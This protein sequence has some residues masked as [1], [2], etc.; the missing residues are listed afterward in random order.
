MNVV[1]DSKARICEANLRTLK[2]GLDIYAAENDVMPGD[3]SQLPPSY[4]NRAYAKIMSEKGAWRIKLAAAV[5]SWDSRN[6][7]MASVGPKPAGLMQA[8]SK[9]DVALLTC[10]SDPTPP[11]QG[12]IS[13]GLWGHLKDMTALEYHDLP[14]DTLL[15]A[16]CDGESF[17]QPHHLATRHEHYALGAVKSF[18][19]AITKGG[20]VVPQVSQ[21][22]ARSLSKVEKMKV[23]GYVQQQP[24][25]HEQ[26]P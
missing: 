4:V 21:S 24:P 8:I 6:T 2:T 23:K 14:P 12:G 13:Y 16:D 18:S 25:S 22:V 26:E 15:I 17:K 1:E 11:D 19:N 10:P 20:T 9:G 7:A 3:L 5:V